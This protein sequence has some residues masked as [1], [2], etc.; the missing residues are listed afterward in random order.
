MG[1]NQSGEDNNVVIPA[2]KKVVL[3]DHE[4]DGELE[5]DYALNP[6]TDHR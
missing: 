1:N 3:A 6:P 5:D 2:G 4:D